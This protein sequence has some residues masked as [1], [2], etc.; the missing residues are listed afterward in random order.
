MVPMT[1]LTE[2]LLAGLALTLLAFGVIA[3]RALAERARRERETARAA[4][5]E[6]ARLTAL[7]VRAAL[8]QV[9]QAVAAERPPAGVAVDRLAA[10]PPITARGTSVP[11]SR[12]T[13][14]ELARLLTSTRA[15]ANGLPEAVVARI[16]L[17]DSPV[18]LGSEAPPDVGERLL[19]GRL[20]VRPEDLAYLAE[21]L[22]LGADPRVA[23][24]LERLRRA[25]AGGLPSLPAFRRTRTPQ[26]RVEGWSQA[27]DDRLFFSVPVAALVERAGVAGQ[28]LAPGAP[29]GLET[30]VPD[31]T[32]LALRV[33]VDARAGTAGGR[34]RYALWAAVVAGALGL[35]AVRRALLSEAQATA[36]EKA[37]LAGVTHELRT[38][39]SAIRLFGETLAT[40]RGDPK[41][42][43][44][45]VARE[46]ERLE[47]LVERVLAVTRVDEAPTFSPVTPSALVASAV[48]LIR[49]RADSREVT[50]ETRLAADLP[51]AQ[52]DEEAV[53]RAL[54]GL[55]DNAVTHGRERGHV[56]VAAVEDAGVV[57]VAV[58]DDGP[59][60]A[61]RDR[62]RIFGRFVRGS[63]AAAGTGL[64]LHLAEQVARAHGGRI[65]LVTEAGRGSTFTLVLPVVPAT[66]RRGEPGSAS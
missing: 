6:S 60:I 25:P 65:D 39:L 23:S 59:G 62:G 45:L 49:P 24:L 33:A 29:G 26:D 36:R 8:A 57:R 5:V 55:L 56:T 16:A 63:N 2:P 30:E 12:R 44:T 9:E 66:A 20:P 10:P 34:L 27:G 50:L 42:Y 41:E 64:G 3:D 61:R 52:W 13:R 43:G 21:Q 46:S 48:A 35:V 53:R 17:G 15:T 40:G 7:S 32:G 51:Q 38:P 19:S 37:F 22:G 18:S 14:A 28:L 58:S 11:Y 4:A 31:V 47:S 54:L 1:R